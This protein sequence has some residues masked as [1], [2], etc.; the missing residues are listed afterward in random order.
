MKGIEIIKISL[1][2]FFFL[3]KNKNVD[4]NDQA[5]LAKKIN[6]NF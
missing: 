6:F 1:I 3:K 5:R 4:T 2:F